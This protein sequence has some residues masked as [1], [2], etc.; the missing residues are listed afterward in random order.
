MDDQHRRS[1]ASA[2]TNSAPSIL[3]LAG[4]AT[5]MSIRVAATLGLA[6][7]TGSSGA[8]AEHLAAE[9]GTSAPALSR[10][11][12]H[13]VGVG[14]FAFDPASLRYRPTATG[15]QMRADHPADVR[16]LLDINSAGGRA[17][18]AFV[19]LLT[20]IATGEPAYRRPYGRDFWVDLGSHPELRQSFDE[21]MTWRYRVQA[22]QI[23]ERLDWSRYS[24]IFDVG[25]GN[26]T[27]LAAILAAHP[28]VRG[29]VLDLEPTAA[30]AR[31]RFAEA[32][33]GDRA[34]VC[35]Q[36]LRPAADRRRRLP[37][38]GHPA[39]PG[40]RPRPGHP[41]SLSR[42]RCPE[43][44]R[45]GDRI[46]RRR[47]RGHRLRPVPAE[48]LRRSAGVGAGADRVGRRSRAQAAKPAADGR[49]ALEFVLAS[50]VQLEI[51]EGDR[52]TREAGPRVALHG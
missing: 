13:L 47:R 37:A 11:L 31:A 40:R 6:D 52:L 51:G 16:R 26:G 3:A 32:G 1:I 21:Q 33:F 22:P 28:S 10:L 48:V 9:T 5:P 15:D 36:L 41:G 50:G 25:G 19:E 38:L 27:V 14:V 7:R 2:M 43:R 12:D 8:T 30:S 44:R 49:T 20:T 18:L 35:G 34:G 39:R 29:R 24:E 23:A 42:R 17:E 4:L 46:G 45:R